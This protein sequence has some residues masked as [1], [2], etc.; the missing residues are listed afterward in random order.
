MAM[1]NKTEDGEYILLYILSSIDAD[2]C[3]ALMGEI[4]EPTHEK[5]VSLDLPCLP[6]SPFMFQDMVDAQNRVNENFKINYHLKELTLLLWLK[7][8]LWAATIF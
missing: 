2:Y 4:Q 6:T 1:R 5:R 8:R 7:S 3:S